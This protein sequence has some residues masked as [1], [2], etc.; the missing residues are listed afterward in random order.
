MLHKGVMREVNGMEVYCPEKHMGCDWTGDLGKVDCH[1]NLGSRDSGCLFVEIECANKC[2]SMVLRKYLNK[3]EN[4]ECPNRSVESSN[5]GNLHILSEMRREMDAM[6]EEKMKLESDL[7]STRSQLQNL[8]SKVASLEASILQLNMKVQGGEQEKRNYQQRISRL[9]EVVQKVVRIERNQLLN[10]TQIEKLKEECKHDTL[11]LENRMTPLPPFYFTLNN[12]YLDH[13][14]EL[15][16]QSKPFYAFPR[17]YKFI[18]TIYPNGTGRGK[19]HFLSLYVSIVGG[20]YDDE[21]QWP[22]TGTVYVQIYNNSTGV[23]ATRSPVEFE[24]SDSLSFTRKPEGLN[25]TNPGLGYSQW[26]VM[27]ELLEDFCYRGVVKFKVE[28]ISW[29]PR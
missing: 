20:E 3:H 5:G 14:K 2:G 1:L 10:S 8:Q 13:D 23:W 24:E 28:K 27:P 15:Q 18:V 6:R 26:L 19:G 29:R 22:F 9:E 4:E 12:N 7:S 25:A 21:L 17:G 16:W 11:S